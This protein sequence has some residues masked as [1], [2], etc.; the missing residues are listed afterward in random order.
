MTKRKVHQ[1]NAQERLELF[2]AKHWGKRKQYYNTAKDTTVAALDTGRDVLNENKH[3]VGG[4]LATAF[5]LEALEA[6]E[7]IADAEV[8][9]AQANITYA[10]AMAN[11]R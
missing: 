2:A 6:A 7:T 11:R 4:A 9:E 5:G 8:A 1:P 10:E 3:L